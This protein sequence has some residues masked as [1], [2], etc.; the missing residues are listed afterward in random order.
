MDNLSSIVRHSIPLGGSSRPIDSKLAHSGTVIDIGFDKHYNDNNKSESSGSNLGELA[1][2][3]VGSVH[4]CVATSAIVAC[5]GRSNNN[6]A[7]RPK[8]EHV[9]L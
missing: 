7:D 8:P 1:I 6:A 2:V 4:N 9:I 3:R 5:I